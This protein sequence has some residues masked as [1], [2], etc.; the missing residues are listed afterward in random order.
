[1]A[2]GAGEAIVYGPINIEALRNFRKTAIGHNMLAHLRS[3][4]YTYLRKSYYPPGT[5]TNVETTQA[6]LRE[7]VKKA[8]EAVYS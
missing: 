5:L 7:M 1:M 8:R 6:V 3:E 2:P 4:A